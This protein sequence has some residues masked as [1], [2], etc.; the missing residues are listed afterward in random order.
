MYCHLLWFTVYIQKAHKIPISPWSQS[1]PIP[2]PM[3][4]SMESPYSRQPCR[5]FLLLHSFILSSTLGSLT[6][7]SHHR[8]PPAE[9]ILPTISPV[10]IERSILLS[11]LFCLL[12]A[13]LSWFRPAF[14]STLNLSISYRNKTTDFSHML[15]G[16]ATCYN[17]AR[18]VDMMSHRERGLVR[19][20]VDSPCLSP[21]SAQ[22]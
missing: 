7:P 9:L 21:L 15:V 19:D 16:W 1:H 12:C 8:L 2:I 10:T 13:R 22:S 20:S 3:G 4:I 14:E 17:A 6:N 18:H 5:L 11:G